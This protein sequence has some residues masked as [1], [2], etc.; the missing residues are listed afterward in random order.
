MMEKKAASLE[1]ALVSLKLEY[2]TQE[3]E[4]ELNQFRLKELSKHF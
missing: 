3:S 4:F 2:A 1:E